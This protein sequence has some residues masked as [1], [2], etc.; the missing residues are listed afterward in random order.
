MA[1][2]NLGTGLAA[3]IVID[4]MIWRGSGGVAGEIGH[5]PVDPNGL[6]CV[7]GQRGCLETVASGSALRRA[8]PSSAARP[9]RELFAQAD[10]GDPDAVAAR[11]AFLR[12]VATAVRMLVLTVDCDV[13][14]IGGGLSSLGGPLLDGVRSVLG[15]WAEESAFLAAQRLAPSARS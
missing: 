7:C 6:P 13:V 14:V 8:W 12:G 11:A 2:L 10:A 4:G 5:V 15:G 3:G 1:Y 9:A